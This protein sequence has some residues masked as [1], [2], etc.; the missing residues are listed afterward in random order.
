MFKL[1]YIIDQEQKE[2]LRNIKDIKEFV[3]EFEHIIGR[4]QL[5]FNNHEE[6]IIDEDIPN[7]DELL[8][9]WFKFLNETVIYCNKY[10]YAAMQ[11]FESLDVWFQFTVTNDIINVKQVRAMQ[12]DRTHLVVN[13]PIEIQE[14][15]W[16]ETIEIQE[17]YKCILNKTKQFLIDI[18]LINPILME[19]PSLKRLVLLYNQA[20]SLNTF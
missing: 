7:I 8:V 17:F 19:S 18:Q 15:F 16:E 10:N 13:E 12:E 11:L 20:K 3:D 5:I 6:G 2:D 14:V 1:K 9:T 4:I